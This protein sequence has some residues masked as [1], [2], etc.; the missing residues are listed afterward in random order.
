DRACGSSDGVWPAL[1]TRPSQF[2]RPPAPRRR[3]PS[4]PRR[5]RRPLRRSAC[6]QKRAARA[7]GRSCPFPRA[8]YRGLIWTQQVVVELA[9]LLERLLEAF[10]VLEPLTHLRHKFGAQAELAG[11]TTGIGD[12]EN[13]Q[14]MAFTAGALLAI[15]LMAEHPAFKE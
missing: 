2:P 15:G 12:G 9:D 7:A 5:G 11:A 8:L 1:R 14:R 3:G 10:V 13:I 6:H 4:T